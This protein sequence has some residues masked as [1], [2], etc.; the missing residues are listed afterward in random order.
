MHEERKR[1]D[2]GEKERESE[3]ERSRK[4]RGQERR[5]QLTNGLGESSYSAQSSII[6][7]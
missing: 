7:V 5:D 2:E 6:N 3:R 4:R 1:R